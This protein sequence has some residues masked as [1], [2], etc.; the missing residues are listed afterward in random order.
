MTTGALEAGGAVSM[1]TGGGV[2]GVG[3]TGVTLGAAVV[4]ST[5]WSGLGSEVMGLAAVGPSSCTAGS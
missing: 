1:V 2:V 3:T 5:G 4:V